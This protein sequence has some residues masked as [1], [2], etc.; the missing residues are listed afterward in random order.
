MALT[1]QRPAL[2]LTTGDEPVRKPLGAFTRPSSNEGWRSWLTTVDHKKIGIMYGATAMTFFAIGGLEALLIRAQLAQPNGQVLSPEVYNQMFTMHGT[3]MVFLVIMPML[4]AFSNYLIP[5]MIGARDVAFPRLNAFSYWVFLFGGLFLYSSFFLGGAPDN[6]WFNYAPN[7]GV[8]YSP[9]HGIDFWT[10]GLQ[11]TGIASLVGA[12]NLIVTCLNMRAPGM[13]LLRMPVFVWMALVAQFLLLFAIP[14]IT[15][16]LFLLMFDRL[17]GANFFDVSAGADP[18]LWQHL[19]WIFGHPEVYI[20]VLP[21]FGII[22]D[23]IPTFARK[24]LFGY[25]F[26]VF[27]GIAIG[28]MGWGVWAHHMFASG[29]GPVS[30]AAFSLST[31]FIAVPTG[32]KIFNWIGTLWKGK[33]Q[34]T[35]AMLFAVGLV[36]QFTIGGLSGV[37]HAVAPADTQQTDTYF[38]VAHFHYVL[39]GG[40]MFGIFAGIYYWWPKIFG[41]KLSETIGKVHFWLMFAGFNLTFAP[42]H[43]AGL[44]G[45]PRRTATY[46]EG[47]GWDLMNLLSTI[48]SFLIGVSFLVWVYNVVRSRH[49]P[50]AGADPWDGR[51]L[52]WAT[53]SPPPVHNFDVEPTVGHL[54]EWWH[55]KYGEDDRGR[56]VRR[57]NFTYLSTVDEASL[58]RGGRNPV[59]DTSKIHLPSPSYWPIIIALGLPL[60]GY[61]L[62]YTYWLAALGGLILIAGIVGMGLEPSVDP[63]AGHDHHD[64]HHHGPEPDAGS[65]GELVTVGA[66]GD[67]GENADAGSGAGSSGK[68]TP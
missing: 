55:Q 53:S 68:E 3:T 35:V 13:T 61:G 10:L 19:F 44:Q 22:S 51:T 62:I 41:H 2:E 37:M 28:F 14:V 30:V 57:E 12:V 59:V 38:V 52:E 31:M 45:Q 48:G 67:G 1:E 56:P 46:P 5:L 40:S 43:I 24:P 39:F 16:A 18:L 9:G 29:V 54:D 50:H 27:S 11:I 17:Y 7:S 6:G 33:L 15:V 63:E 49:N 8:A 4:A 60:I 47:M 64:D 65:E 66:G 42:M 26:M 23:V 32:V 20:L 58:A 21:A 25:P 34:F 36:S